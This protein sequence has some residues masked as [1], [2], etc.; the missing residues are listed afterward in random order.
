MLIIGVSVNAQLPANSY[1]P[2]FTISAYQP[3]LS[4]AGFH[5]NGEYTL[6]EL[7]DSG[8]TVF[9]D[10][11]ATWC[12]PCFSYHSSGVL[13]DLYY[14]HGPAGQ[15]GVS[16]TTTDDVIVIWVDADSITSDASMT[17]NSASWNWI[18][19]TPGDS[20]QY[21]MSNI[22]AVSAMQFNNAYGI[23][24]YPTI[25]KICPNRILN[26]V[27]Q[28]STSGLYAGVTTCP[29]PATDNLDAAMFSYN[30][31]IYFCSGASITP[32]VTI[33]NYGFN[34]LTNATV[35]VTQDQTVVS[36]GTYSGNLTTYA[37]ATV[38]CSTITNPSLG[39]IEV[40][41][42]TPGETSFSNNTVDTAFYHFTAAPAPL[43]QN[44]GSFAPFPY[45]YYTLSSPTNENWV[46]HIDGML[47]YE[48]YN[49]SSG[50]TS[51]LVIEPVDLSTVSNPTL[52]FDVAYVG[53]T[54]PPD[55]SEND[56]LEVF[57]STN[58]GTTWTTIYSKQGDILSTGMPNDNPFT[59]TVAD[60]WRTELV[61][62]SQYA[63]ETE[64]FIKF[65]ATSDFGNNMYLDNI[66]INSL[67]GIDEIESSKISIYPNPASS[68]INVTFD[69][70]GGEYKITI[71]D[72]I[73]RTVA[74]EIVSNTMGQTLIS[75]PTSEF[76]AGI[77]FVTVA[78]GNDSY[79][80]KL[81]VQ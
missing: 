42:S 17:V 48:C 58:C 65:V 35:T 75:I 23:N 50:T 46:R 28:L 36:T 18:V 38:T 32:V 12:G 26:E 40:S 64:V 68:N 6:Y 74:N 77:Y 72:I 44:F 15:P 78:N 57:V 63:G 70:K 73:G 4:N 56:K 3:W 51:S 66:N 31:G 10:V 29:A 54:M 59:P 21:P 52:L 9:L 24:Y 67:V 8:Y 37:L 61:S 62:L 14:N 27:G 60:D 76:Q 1:A 7:L 22:P 5:N 45:T 81:V 19:P 25:Y 11:S 34:P 16:A 2:N 71:T 33:Q 80:Q 79:I 39:P 69:G 55:P 41:V 47:M 53:Y 43:T 20:I 30:G 49:Y 13:E